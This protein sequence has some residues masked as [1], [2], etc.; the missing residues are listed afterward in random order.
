MVDA[1]KSNQ[2]LTAI[3]GS[4]TGVR[5]SLLI[6]ILP[7][8]LYCVSVFYKVQSSIDKN[9][10]TINRMADETKELN[11]SI[12]QHFSDPTIHHRAIDKLSWRIGT[13]EGKDPK[14][15]KE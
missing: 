4:K 7:S 11:K 6:V 1:N 12:T 9:T 3:I 8:A 10:D 14:R 15:G 5:I 2:N 13:L